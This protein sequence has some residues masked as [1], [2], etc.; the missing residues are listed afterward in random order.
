MANNNGSFIEN[1][2]FLEQAKS[3]A[4][5]LVTSKKGVN[6]NEAD[7][8]LNQ[9]EGTINREKQTLKTKISNELQDNSIKAQ[10]QVQDM[11]EIE[12][13]IDTQI[14]FLLDERAININREIEKRKND[15]II[16]R[17]YTLT[18]DELDNTMLELTEDYMNGV[19]E[20]KKGQ[21]KQTL[22]KIYGS[23]KQEV[24]NNY[25]KMVRENAQ[26]VG[27]EHISNIATLYD[28][29]N[30]DTLRNVIN[31]INYKFP[32]TYDSN[33]AKNRKIIEEKTIASLSNLIKPENTKEQNDK[34]YNS[35]KTYLT[36]QNGSVIPGN[37][38]PKLGEV[39][40]TKYK[41]ILNQA[42]ENEEK[43]I[44]MTNLSIENEL[45]NLE[46]GT[47]S[48][49]KILNIENTL[50][51]ISNGINKSQYLNSLEK[52]EYLSKN[53]KKFDEIGKYKEIYSKGL[54]EN[55]SSL[56]VMEQ[57]DKKIVEQM[58]DNETKKLLQ[59]QDFNQVVSNITKTGVM[60]KTLKEDFNKIK[61]KDEETLKNSY[62][63]IKAFSKIDNAFLQNLDKDQRD[64]FF[65]Y[66]ALNDTGSKIEPIDLELI[67][68]SPEFKKTDKKSLADTEL[69]VGEKGLW[70]SKIN[71]INVLDKEEFLRE[72]ETFDLLTAFKGEEFAKSVMTKK[73]ADKYKVLDD[74]IIV[75][76]S[77]YNVEDFNEY[78]KELQQEIGMELKGKTLKIKNDN[79]Y[80]VPVQINELADGNKYRYEV[81]MDTE[82][83]IIRKGVEKNFG[84]YINNKRNGVYTKRKQDA[85]IKGIAD[86]DSFE[87]NYEPTVD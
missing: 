3:S 42:K 38:N 26:Q 44:K 70:Q 63:S 47:S 25:V 71:L 46:Q 55:L 78:I 24:D 69:R 18:P 21:F 17:G 77:K 5:G 12:K 81:E 11:K 87:N 39:I 28:V 61:S 74:E 16:K 50:L 53:M 2:A 45:Y 14:G 4:L 76:D 15:S 62:A 73:I 22:S 51:K 67:K 43:S 80:Y 23:H 20:S 56:S 6:F 59:Q 72:S 9:L 10:Y 68:K 60:P 79:L 86:V 32:A 41:V 85:Y 36:T 65:I 27:D 64:L 35:I 29:S 54:I 30:P 58:Y 34:I 52:Q 40:D 13:D 83:F 49:D 8:L 82:D 37:L 75:K 31:Q 66:D 1:I 33:K 7:L 84:K 19:P 57:T 48:I